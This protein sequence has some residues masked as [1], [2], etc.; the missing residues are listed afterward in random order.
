MAT[1]PQSNPAREGPAY[2]TIISG[3]ITLAAVCLIAGIGCLLPGCSTDIHNQAEVGFR[4]GTEV[5]F[6][7]RSAQT[8]PEHSTATLKFPPLEEWFLRERNQAT[9][10]S[11][12]TEPTP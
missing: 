8:A 2:G 11:G 9:P 6:F 10:A 12:V 4:W 5:T 3:M 1:Q 7:S